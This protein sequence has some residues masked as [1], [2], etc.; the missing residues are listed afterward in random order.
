[1]KKKSMVMVVRTT[2]NMLNCNSCRVMN[3]RVHVLVT[4][5]TTGLFLRQD[6]YRLSTFKLVKICLD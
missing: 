5:K 1:M 4:N 3:F 6:V 2:M